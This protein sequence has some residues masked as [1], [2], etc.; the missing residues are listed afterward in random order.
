MR[1]EEDSDGKVRL[2]DLPAGAVFKNPVN[3]AYGMRTLHGH[4]WIECGTDFR[5]H[6]GFEARNM[7]TQLVIPMPNARVVLEP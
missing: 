7:M 5:P 3:G 4:V 2:K 6:D 1:I